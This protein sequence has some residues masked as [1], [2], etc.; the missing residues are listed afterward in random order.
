VKEGT[1]EKP[2]ALPPSIYLSGSGSRA[3]KEG[4]SA[5]RGSGEKPMLPS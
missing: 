1:G 3:V 4:Q 2:V 5:N